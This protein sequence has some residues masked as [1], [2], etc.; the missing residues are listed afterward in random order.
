MI[1]S[2]IRVMQAIRQGK[3]GGGETHMFELVSR[4]DKSVFSPEV[5]SFTPGPMVDQIS[6]MGIPV[7]IIETERGFDWKIWGRVKK[8]LINQKIDIVHAHGTRANTNVFWAARNLKLPLVYTIHGWSFH[9]DQSKLVKNI[10]ML[11][12]WFLTSQTT[13]NI[14]VSFSNQQD[15]VKKFNMKNSTVIFNG[16]STEKFDPTGKY[17]DIRKEL[18]IPEEKTL[19]GYIVRITMQKDPMTLIEAMKMVMEV[20]KDVFLLVVGEGDLKEKIVQMTRDYGLSSHVVF[21]NFRQDV[22]DILH[23]TDIYCLPSLWEGLPIGILEAM[24]M[25]K[26]IIATPIDGTKE[27][28]IDNE[29]GLFVPQQNPRLLADA[30]I[31]VHKNKQL[32][33]K[34]SEN[35]IKTIVEK[36]TISEMVEKIENHYK[37]IIK[38]NENWNR[39]TTN[40]P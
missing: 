37:L 22:P 13:S 24:S 5:L 33:K 19:I 35:A 36:F 3:V 4:M 28:I 8:L 7:H 12:E 32:Q 31:K 11:S 30:I 39:S 21:E 40:I 38:C 16:I 25:G 26:V 18:N 27:I 15:G 1:G 29:N 6:K 10:R 34:L 14:C 20:T 9:Q 23:A 2:K 17:A